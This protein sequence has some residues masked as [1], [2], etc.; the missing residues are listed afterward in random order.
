MPIPIV[1][2]LKEVSEKEWE[3]LLKELV[4]NSMYEMVIL[5]VGESVQGLFRI[6]EKCNRIY[7]PILEDE[8]SKNKLKQYDENL[9]QLNLEKI[10]RTTTR[11]VILEP[12][13][14]Y[15]RARAKEEI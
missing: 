13:E 3:I 8:I 2:D 12:I 1:Q 9:K 5:D 14:E 7:M 11:F 10:E 6:L 4:E 15:A